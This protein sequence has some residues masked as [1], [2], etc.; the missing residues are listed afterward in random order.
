MPQV[1]THDRTGLERLYLTWIL[2]APPACR[3]AGGRAGPESPE[4]RRGERESG[5]PL[6]RT[7]SGGLG[8]TRSVF[9]GPGRSDPGQGAGARD[10][11]GRAV[12]CGSVAGGERKVRVLR[13]Q[14]AV[15]RPAMPKLARLRQPLSVS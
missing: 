4:R 3:K 11:V 2:P 5:E 13:E 14:G 6:G 12:G 1:L 7:R 9:V 10:S 15:G 8:P